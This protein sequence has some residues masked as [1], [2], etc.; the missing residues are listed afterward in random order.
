[1]KN[2]I[3]AMPSYFQSLHHNEIIAAFARLDMRKWKI[4]NGRRFVCAQ[5]VRVKLFCCTLCDM[6]SN[7]EIITHYDHLDKYVSGKCIAKDT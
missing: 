7:T 5:N 6:Q 4:S 3:Y 2:I 1:M